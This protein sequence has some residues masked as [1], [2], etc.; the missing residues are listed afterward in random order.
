MSS[1]LARFRLALASAVASRQGLSEDA[2]PELER[3]IRRPNADQGDLAFPCFT[4]AKTL[5]QN[6]AE[7]AKTLAAALAED[8]RWASVEAVGP[9]VNVTYATRLLAETVVPAARRDGYG[10][11]ESGRGQTVVIDFSSPNIAKPLAFHH[12]RSTVIGASIANL[13]RASGWTVAGINY[14]GDWG[15]QFGLLATGFQRYGDPD[16]RADAKHLVEV[17]VKANREADV[18]RVKDAIEA[19]K[20]ARE[21]VSELQAAHAKLVS[22]AG[23][24]FETQKK[25]GKQVKALEK[26]LRAL[27]GISD[28]DAD[29]L[30]DG[31][32]DWL[33]RLE[34]AAEAAKA[35]LPQVEA[36]DQEARAFLKK[37]EDKDEAA[38]AEWQEFRRTS[39][40]EFEKVYARMG[41]TFSSIEGE[42]FYQDKLDATVERVRDKPG[43]RESEGAEVIDM[44]Y[45]KGEPP[46]IVKTRDGTTLYITRDIAAAQDRFQRFD[47][48]RSLYVVAQDQALHFRQLFRALGSMGFEWADR[49]QH[50]AFGRVHGMSTRRGQVVFLD[51]VLE[52]ACAKARTI[53]EQSDKIAPEHLDDAVEAIGVGAVMFGDLRNLRTSDYTFDWDQVL[54]FSGHTAPYVQFSHARACS[55]LRKGGGVPAAADP[56]LLTLPEERALMVA[57]GGYPDAVKEACDAYEPSLVVRALIDIAQSTASYLTA[58]NRD[59]GMRVLVEDSEALKGARLWLIDGVR[60]CLAHG[61]G[62]LCCRA[63]EAM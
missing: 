51:E 11:N 10:E 47:F 6:P 24:D 14:L 58:G 8:D 23:A 17:Y 12:I 21:L 1:P 26:K 59:R 18:G 55:I 20:M 38:L 62:L 30:S 34:A 28:G 3:Q 63:P 60:H 29:P 43:T 41:I 33:H 27:R 53:C 56:T 42:S 4:L 48:Q 15:K 50:V 9:Y 19:P 37:M 13:H 35:E 2:V 32:T 54:D 16:K 25:M 39:I 57:L 22:E 5:R 31:C 46:A 7:L 61:L 49:C 40:E 45:D 44:T 52:E 36:R